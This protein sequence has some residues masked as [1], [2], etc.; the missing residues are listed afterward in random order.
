MEGEVESN[1]TCTDDDAKSKETG[2]KVDTESTANDEDHPD[3]EA[4]S[5]ETGGKVDTEP[6]AKDEDHNVD[7]TKSNSCPEN[8]KA[9]TDGEDEFDK[10]SAVQLKGHRNTAMVE[11]EQGVINIM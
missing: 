3:D 6:T 9:N 11:K 5:K 7:H 4:K 2:G 10:G 8:D 1:E